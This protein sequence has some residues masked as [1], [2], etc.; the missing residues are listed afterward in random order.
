MEYIPFG[1]EI[2]KKLME[3]Y[4]NEL[5]DLKPFSFEFFFYSVVRAVVAFVIIPF[6]LIVGI[7]TVGWMWP[8]QIRVMFFTQRISHQNSRDLNESEQ[9]T[10]QVNNLK[11]E[12]KELGL[13]L[14]EEIGID[15][16]EVGLIKTQLTDAKA[17]IDTEMEAIKSIVSSLFELQSRFGA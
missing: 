15:K 9:R 1:R 11:T 2:W 17:D 14:R 8:P 3:L 7:F 5:V 16:R 12:I 6:W 13:Q 10:I 4:D